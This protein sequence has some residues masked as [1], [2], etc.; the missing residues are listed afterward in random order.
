M[1]VK[2]KVSTLCLAIFMIILIITLPDISSSGV[3]RG[4]IISANVIIPSLFPFM[5]CVLM[6][7][8]SGIK[9]NNKTVN[10][11]LYKVFGQNFDMFFVFLLSM[12]GGYP[13]GAK[14]INEL[15]SQET[16]DK[17]TAN[18]M[19]TYCVNAGPAFIISVV[20]GVFSSQKIGIVLLVSHILSSFLIALLCS[21]KNKKNIFW[22]KKN[23]KIQKNFSEN[24]VESVADASGSML[25]ICSFIILFSVINSYLDYFFC[26]MPIIKYISI[27]TEV[28]SAVV[29]C[30]NLYLVSF[31][32]GF[33]GLSIW[34]QIFAI[35]GKRKINIISFVIGRILHGTISVIITRFL[36]YIFKIKVYTFSNNVNLNNKFYYSNIT[37]FIS[38][39]IMIIV[40]F[41]F[42]CS[43]NNSGKIIN[44]VL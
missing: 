11:I 27:F 19:L 4:L 2:S 26:N 29:K 13:V 9:L 25:S 24:F 28:T 35:S 12:I 5:V 43:K 39:L 36:V 6:L 34:C 40:L 20:G 42:F 21:K 38:M 32:L 7:I 33:S 16:I 14:L 31:L 23:I 18:I 3:S 1:T 41:T 17:K 30:K 37:L 15:Y 10:Q 8:K 44:D 22:N